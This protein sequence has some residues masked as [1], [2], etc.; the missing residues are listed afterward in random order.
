MKTTTRAALTLAIAALTSFRAAEAS[1]L[2]KILGG[3]GAIKAVKAKAE[4]I[5]KA[6]GKQLELVEQ[7]PFAALPALKKGLVDAV[8]FGG[9]PE[10]FFA[11]EDVKK[12]DFGTSADYDSFTFSESQI[13]AV[14]NS[15][16][17]VTSLSREQVTGLLN[18]K[19]KTWEKI[20]GRKDSVKVIFN[21]SQNAALELVARYYLHES[22]IKNAEYVSTVAAL[23]RKI[24]L[25]PGAI[26]FS[27]SKFE[28]E[29]AEP[30]F[31]DIELKLVYSIIA[32][33]PLSAQ[34]EKL[35]GALKAKN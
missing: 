7:M 3:P 24:Q 6:T 9:A 30:K 5:E 18:G 12:T 33:K 19:T 22:G 15:E 8:V 34:N 4:K 31:I 27:G 26:G 35:F 25:D 17:P 21:R 23:A 13:K 16:N 11:S 2:I 1:D 28:I 20:N 29:G 14:I 10:D 32:K